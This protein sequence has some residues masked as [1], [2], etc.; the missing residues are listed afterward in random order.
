[1][2]KNHLKLMVKFITIFLI[3]L[4][5]SVNAQQK[6]VITL[7]NGEWAPYQS[8]KLKN[9]GFAS[10]IITE[11]FKYG[12]VEV[13]FSFRPWK[14]GMEESKN[15]KWNGTFLWFDT[16][17]RRKDFYISD[18]V[19]DI[20]YVF[21]YTK[22]TNFDWAT[23]N[24]LAKYKIGGTI[25]YNYGEEFQKAEKEKKIKVERIADDTQNFKKILL[26]R[27]QIF[28]CDADAGFEIIRKNFSP[29]EQKKFTYHKK[30]IKKAPHHLLLSKSVKG[31]KELIQT[32]NMGLKK[33]AD[34][35][36]INQFIENSRKGGYIKNTQ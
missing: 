13:K 27:I 20:Q 18:P 16:E 12:N 22:G 7:C 19:V 35:G 32:F 26:G 17:E 9:F 29:Q 8:E 23:V 30:P 15:G 3:T 2:K 36:K 14:R 31:N 33:L 6:K 10:H 4:F 1:M 25:E 28:P 34:S 11:A 5:I 24:D 21:F